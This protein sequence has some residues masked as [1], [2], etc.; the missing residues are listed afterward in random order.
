MKDSGIEWIGEI[1]EDWNMKRVKHSFRRKNEKAMQEDP[2][3]L[4]LARSGVKIRDVSNNEGQ[5]AE[6]YYNYNPVEVD[7]ILIN[8]MDL[9]SGDNC[10]ISKVTGVISPAYINLKNND[11]VNPNFYN[12]YFKTQ[13]WLMAFFAHG[14]G[15]SFE[16]RWTLNTETLMNYPIVNPSYIEQKRIS[17]YLDTHCTLIDQTIEKQKQVIE[18]LKQYKQSIITEAVTKGL[19]PNV[20]MKDSGIE[21]IGE[22]PQTWKIIRVKYLLEEINDKSLSG[23]EEPLSMSQIRGIIPSKE[24]DIPNPSTSYVGN[25]IV[26]IDDLVFNKLKAHLGVFSVSKYEGIVSPDYA[27]YRN[28]GNCNVTFIE[29]LFKTTKSINEFKKYIKGVG[30]GLSR[31]YTSDLFDIKIALPD[32]QE[33]VKIAGYI[34]SRI[35]EVDSS[36][37]VKEKTIEKLEYYKKSL[38]YECVTGKREVN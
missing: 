34:V 33:Q 7:D 19:N 18:K 37:M 1:P 14:K 16:N 22:I 4:S 23:M 25:K 26:K 17:N 21:W 27:V 24:L 6:S 36:I 32:L 31:L 3:V 30:A 2:I 13:Y 28:K 20:P 10:N 11:Y 5:V 8:P 35:L 29:Y 12:Y 9:Y 38:I 15:V